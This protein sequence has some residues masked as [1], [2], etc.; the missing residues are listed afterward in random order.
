MQRDQNKC[1][2]LLYEFAGSFDYAIVR[3]WDHLSFQL[4]IPTIDQVTSKHEEELTRCWFRC[5][6]DTIFVMSSIS[7]SFVSFISVRIADTASVRWCLHTG[8]S[9][10]SDEREICNDLK[11]WQGNLTENKQG[12]CIQCD[13]KLWPQ[14]PAVGRN[15]KCRYVLFLNYLAKHLMMKL[16]H[17]HF[18]CHYADAHTMILCDSVKSVMAGHGDQK[19]STPT[20]H[21]S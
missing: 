20:R 21:Y 17:I 18:F 4:E 11:K 1:R 2:P 14:Q 12:Q 9:V 5:C 10:V 13:I 3:E 16:I 15:S 6:I 8:R 7:V 19:T